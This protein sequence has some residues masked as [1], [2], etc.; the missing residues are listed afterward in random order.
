MTDPTLTEKDREALTRAMEIASREPRR[1]EQLESMLEDR[2]WRE[3]AEFAASVCQTKALSLY[4][5][6]VGPSDVSEHD[7]D[8]P[9]DL[10]ARLSEQ[11]EPAAR[12]LL[13]RMLA[14]GLSRFEPDPITALAR[15]EKPR[16]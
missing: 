11:S 7:E 9:V 1:R 14:A 3:V 16:A 12:K 6:E 13:R 8:G 2:P 5:W 4:P 15:V 10:G